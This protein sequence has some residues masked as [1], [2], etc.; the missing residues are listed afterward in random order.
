MGGTNKEVFKS[1]EDYIRYEIKCKQSNEICVMRNNDLQPLHSRRYSRDRSEYIY[2]LRS[3]T[4]RIKLNDT[5]NCD[6]SNMFH[7]IINKN[8]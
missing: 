8:I 1:K 5:N 3:Y 7:Y 2:A 4:S 6:C